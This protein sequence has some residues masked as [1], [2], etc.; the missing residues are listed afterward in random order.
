MVRVSAV[1]ARR[2]LKAR[3]AR[4]MLLGAVVSGC[5]EANGP[6]GALSVSV[7]GR[8]ERGATG[9]VQAMVGRQPLP[10]DALTWSAQPSAV[11]LFVS[12]GRAPLVRA[13]H[14]EVTASTCRV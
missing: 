7:A 5:G 11:L 12:P 10:G 13:T 2:A 4:G 1:Q 8:L 3:V 9:A 14:V 6:G